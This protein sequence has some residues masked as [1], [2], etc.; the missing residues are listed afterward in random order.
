MIKGTVQLQKLR[1]GSVKKWMEISGGEKLPAASS[2]FCL[3]ECSMT[4]TAKKKRRRKVV[5]EARVLTCAQNVT[6][7]K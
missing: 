7:Q 1:E 6:E 5:W 3:Q 2:V 4:L